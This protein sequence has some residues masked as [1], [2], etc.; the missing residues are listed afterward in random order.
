MFLGKVETSNFQVLLT[1]K[2]C[3][4][5]PYDCSD[6]IG[7]YEKKSGHFAF[8]VFSRCPKRLMTALNP[9]YININSFALFPKK[10]DFTKPH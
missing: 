10:F 4:I 7:D 5:N 9:V 1:Q 3:F 8:K 2:K 6:V